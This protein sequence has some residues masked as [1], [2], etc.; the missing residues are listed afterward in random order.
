VGAARLGV[1]RDAWS[2]Y[3]W[4]RNCI[5]EKSLVG[6]TLLLSWLALVYSAVTT[7]FVS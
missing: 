5:S 1:A 7:I 6:L 3:L 2:W 4:R